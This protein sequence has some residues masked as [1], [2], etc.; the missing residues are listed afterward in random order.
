MMLA[1][2]YILWFTCNGGERFVFDNHQ[3]THV[4]MSHMDS[5]DPR[6]GMTRPLASRDP[7]QIFCVTP[8]AGVMLHQHSIRRPVWC[9]T[10]PIHHG[11]RVVRQDGFM[12]LLPPSS[13]LITLNNS[14]EVDCPL[15]QFS[16]RQELKMVAKAKSKEVP[17]HSAVIGGVDTYV[18]AGPCICQLPTK[19]RGELGTLS[20]WA[21]TVS[22]PAQV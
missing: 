14:G 3:D 7:Y 10:R 1:Q 21:P 20:Q 9:D 5:K 17:T 15:H 2:R 12:K 18:S 22:T 6:Y 11:T 19:K 8:D 4:S 13:P 16:I